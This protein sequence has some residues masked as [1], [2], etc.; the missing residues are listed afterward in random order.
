MSAEEPD[1]P[2]RRIDRIDRSPTRVLVLERCPFRSK[3]NQEF[4]SIIQFPFCCPRVAFTIRNKTPFPFVVT[5]DCAFSSSLDDRNEHLPRA[6][7]TL[8][9]FHGNN[10]I[11]PYLPARRSSQDLISFDPHSRRNCCRARCE[12]NTQQNDS[13]F[14]VLPKRL[15]T[16]IAECINRDNCLKQFLSKKSGVYRGVK[17]DER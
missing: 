12:N 2:E 4:R 14:H 3:Q 17:C 13:S 15:T 8:H 6:G 11:P 16:T 10:R 7:Q 5:L 9:S 1:R